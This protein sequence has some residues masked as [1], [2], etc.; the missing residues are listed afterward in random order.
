MNNCHS[1]T[2]VNLLNVQKNPNHFELE[3]R[4]KLDLRS[5]PKNSDSVQAKKGDVTRRKSFGPLKVRRV[6]VGQLVCCLLRAK[7]SPMNL[8]SDV[9]VKLEANADNCECEASIFTTL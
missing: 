6:G 9:C 4:F 1:I 5:F 8:N 7:K 3:L 2:C